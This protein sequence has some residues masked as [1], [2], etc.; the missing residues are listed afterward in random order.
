MRIG[1]TGAAVSG[2][3]L[4]VSIPMAGAAQTSLFADDFRAVAENCATPPARWAAAADEACIS[5]L[6]ATVSAARRASNEAQYNIEL[7]ALSTEIV[8]AWDVSIAPSGCIR[9]ANALV[10]VSI[11]VTDAVLQQN[12]RAV[13]E[14]VRQC[15]PV[16]L[17]TDQLLASPN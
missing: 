8:A 13:S 6:L 7:A 4:A 17:N 2:L 1:D 5:E 15:A 11:S 9:L 16:G 14:V 10:E 12:I 3:V